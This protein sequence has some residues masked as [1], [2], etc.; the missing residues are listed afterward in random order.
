[1]QNPLENS[2]QYIKSV[3]PKRAELFGKIGINTIGDLLFYF[4]SRYLDRS[5]LLTSAKAFHYVH[6]GYEGEITILAKVENSE[7]RYFRGKEILTVSFRDAS[8]FFECIWFQG[9]KYHADK[10][11]PGR[12]FALSGKP[13]ISKIGKLQLIHPDYDLL[14]EDE[15]QKFFNTGRIIPVYSIPKEL[16]A[17][18]IGDFS[19]RKIISSAVEQYTQYISETLPDTLLKKHGLISL[20]SCVSILHNP[21]GMQHIEEARRRLKYEEL[22]YIEMLV[23]LRRYN[24]RHTVKSTAMKIKTKLIHSFLKILPYE[25]TASQKHVLHEIR[26]DLEKQEPMNRLLQGDVGSGKTIVALIAMLIAVDNGFQAALM[27][28]T[29]ILADQ[30]AKNIRSLLSRLSEQY[31]EYT[32]NV[33]LLLGGQKKKER[34]E[35]IGNINSGKTHIIVGTHA[36]FEDN[37]FRANLGL[38]VIDEQHRFGVAQ[39]ARLIE[40]QIVPNC[41]VMSATPIPRTLSMTLYGDLDISVINEMPKNRMPIKTFLRGESRLR[42]IYEFIIKESAKGNR[43]FIVYPRVEESEKLELKA[44]QTHDEELSEGIL[45]GVRGG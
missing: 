27:V 45:K 15:S 40:K 37:D 39:R 9:A 33:S 3:G 38:V 34:E 10:F 2:I 29:E 43:A 41:L 6:N 20:Q 23:A 22:F 21:P 14:S 12:H 25:L 7:R 4:P 17:G 42:D 24:I 28:P 13:T 8:G 35:E 30:H 36:L 26:T 1:M 19:M 18:N 16:K 44:A 31:P 32:L 11:L 5:N